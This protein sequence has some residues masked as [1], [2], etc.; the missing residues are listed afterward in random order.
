[1]VFFDLFALEFEMLEMKNTPKAICR[2]V[3]ELV[4]VF[5][6]KCSKCLA[7]HIH[8]CNFNI[9]E[10]LLEMRKGVINRLVRPVEIMFPSSST[11]WMS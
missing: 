3:P 1:M 2:L 5:V 9:F 7:P 10:K 11:V 6:G 4:Y 8:P